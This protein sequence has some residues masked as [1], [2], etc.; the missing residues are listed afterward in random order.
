MKV[1]CLRRMILAAILLGCVMLASTSGLEAATDPVVVELHYQNGVKFYKRG[2]YDKAAGEF[3]R[4]LVLEPTHQE[5]KDFLEK[6]QKMDEKQRRVEAKKSQDAQLKELYQ[7][8]KKLYS[9]HDFQGALDVFNKILKLKPIDDFASF[10]RER[11]EIFIARKLAKEKSVEQKRL[12]KERKLKEK[13]N[14]IKQKQL[15]LERKQELAQE[16]MRIKEQRQQDLKNKKLAGKQKAQ[17]VVV[18]Q[19]EAVVDT[20]KGQESAK[21]LKVSETPEKVLTAKEEAVARKKRIREE[22]IAAAKQRREEKIAAAKSRREEKLALAE[23]RKAEKLAKQEKMRQAREQ[24]RQEKILAAQAKK[25][26]QLKAKEAKRAAA[27]NQ[28]TADSSAKA[29][30]AVVDKSQDQKKNVSEEEAVKAAKGVALEKSAKQLYL[31]G[32]EHLGRKEYAQAIASFS[33]VIEQEKEGS[34]LYTN[35]ST[36]LREKAKQRL[37]QTAIKKEEE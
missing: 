14:R 20:A 23:Q 10:Y 36:R 21:A 18:R 4:T 1:L 29:G 22:K 3:Q 7:Q 27:K 12:L 8:G 2:L 15:A 34:K 24:A 32:A 17:E 16:R 5:A 30:K 25:E 6:I 28:K 33:A 31:E 37:Q 26:A 19:E 13:E 11:C 35:A 9:Q